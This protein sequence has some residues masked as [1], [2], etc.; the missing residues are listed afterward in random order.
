VGQTRIGRSKDRPLKAP[1]E[2]PHGASARLKQEPNAE[3]P[4]PL[5]TAD[6]IARFLAERSL[7]NGR[8]GVVVWFWVLAVPLL[9][10]SLFLALANNWEGFWVLLAALITGRALSISSA[11]ACE[12]RAALL[13][14]ELDQTWIGPLIDALAYPNRT[15]RNISRLRLT[16]LLP[17]LNSS[18]SEGL[19]VS[20]RALLFDYLT[21]WYA[22]YQPDFLCAIIRFGA[23][24]GDEQAVAGTD[25]LAGMF[26]YTSAQ[27]KVRTEARRCLPE[28][29]KRVAERLAATEGFAEFA[30]VGEIRQEEPRA[31]LSIQAQSWLDEIGAE[32]RARPGM[33]FGYLLASWCVIVPYM[34]YQAVLHFGRGELVYAGLFTLAAVMATQLYRLTLTPE[35]LRLA[36]KLA[37]I[38][39]VQAVGPLAEM[40]V[41]PDQRMKSMAMAAL[42]RLLPR[43]KASDTQLLS[44]DQRTCLYESLRLENAKRCLD[45][46]IA[47]LTALQ[48]VGD[49]KALPY[50]RAL[51]GSTAHTVRERSV[52]KAANECL[53]FLELC[54]RDNHHSQILLRA[55]NSPVPDA[56]L[57][58]PAG[59][60]ADDDP[61]LLLRISG[62][63]EPEL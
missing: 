52:V 40:T 8:G 36:G 55:I 23:K 33:R 37:S 49:I 29:E 51:A 61:E 45:Y 17:T 59:R 58:R 16:T 19:S 34:A 62:P 39:D 21:P 6:D 50:V 47:V 22:I 60:Y 42:T 3:A 46:Q 15:A 20:R 14:P 11:Q 32:S 13:T 56:N 38:D 35:Q 41:W 26:A 54:A 30:S 53:P 44:P 25:S 28:L 9:W 24:L 10:L 7:P 48:Q 63:P 43:L 2:S 57:V 4:T 27:R 1:E 31:Q 5:R 12:Y 18:D